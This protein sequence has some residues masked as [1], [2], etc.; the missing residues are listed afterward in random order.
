MLQYRN[1]VAR[2]PNRNVNLQFAELLASDGRS[3]HI[4][5]VMLRGPDWVEVSLPRGLALGDALL[6]RF[7][8]SR[9]CY[10]V[11]KAWQNPDCV[12]LNFLEAPPQTLPPVA[13][14]ARTGHPTSAA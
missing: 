3:L 2:I 12:G 13:S 14:Q 10:N 7:H 11:R 4:G 1:P 5:C 6:V 9:H 8:P